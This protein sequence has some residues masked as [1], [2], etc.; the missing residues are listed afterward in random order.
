MPS[1]RVSASFTPGRR[2]HPGHRRALHAVAQMLRRRRRCALAKT[3][4]WRI[5]LGG[6]ASSAMSDSAAL[7][8]SFLTML[9]VGLLTVVAVGLAIRWWRWRMRRR[10]R[11]SGV[12]RA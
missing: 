8:L 6:R 11:I 7:L 9:A 12:R 1:Q 3:P 10:R 4:R 5:L 2:R